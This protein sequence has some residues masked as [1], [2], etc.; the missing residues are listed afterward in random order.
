MRCHNRVR[1]LYAL[2]FVLVMASLL[3][4]RSVHAQEAVP[5]PPVDDEIQYVY[6]LVPCGLPYECVDLVGF[7]NAD[8]A[9]RFSFDPK[10]PGLYDI[11]HW[12][13]L[14]P[15][16]PR[17]FVAQSTKHKDTLFFSYYRILEKRRYRTWWHPWSRRAR[18]VEFHLAS[19][20]YGE[21]SLKLRNLFGLANRLRAGEDPKEMEF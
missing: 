9:W 21:Q 3:C 12:Q 8:L 18:W 15:G 6:P 11:V 19:R 14:G 16:K 2:L 13:V 7:K 17:E 4:G 5:P 1:V 20:E 10:R